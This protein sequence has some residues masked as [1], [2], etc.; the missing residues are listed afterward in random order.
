MATGRSNNKSTQLASRVPHDV[1]EGMESVKL[2]GET[3][4]QFIVTAMQGEIKRRQR[5]KA[6]A[7]TPG[8]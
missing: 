1:V 3:T 8:E 7:E 6:K 4:G 5:R 2:D